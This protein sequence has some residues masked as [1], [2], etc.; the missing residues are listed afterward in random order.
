MRSGACPPQGQ[1][2]VRWN[3]KPINVDPPIIF[4]FVSPL[5]RV[6]GAAGPSSRL[7]SR[8]HPHVPPLLHHPVLSLLTSGPPIAVLDVSAMWLRVNVVKQFWGVLRLE[9]VDGQP[10]RGDTAVRES[11]ALPPPLLLSNGCPCPTTTLGWGL[12]VGGI[13]H[14]PFSA[15]GSMNPVI[16]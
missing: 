15:E 7:R 5:G 14:P 11:L 2:G 3:L 6:P 10:L 13:Q 16:G 4:K 12:Q 8:L 9:W 1:R